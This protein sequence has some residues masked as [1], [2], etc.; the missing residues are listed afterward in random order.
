MTFLQIIV[1][2]AIFQ[3]VLGYFAQFFTD[4]PVKCYFATE[5]VW[6]INQSLESKIVTSPPPQSV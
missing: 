1:I 5:I 4:L 6:Q 2:F 3:P